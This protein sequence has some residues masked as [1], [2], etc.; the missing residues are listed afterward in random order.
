MKALYM[1]DSY[2]KEF[3]T[4]VKKADGKYIVLE[5][6]AFYPKS[7]GQPFDTGKIIDEE[8]NEYKVVFTGKFDGEISHEVDKEGLS[9]GKNVKGI[10]DWERRYKLMRAH[11]ASHILSAVFH[12]EAG[13]KITGNQL[14]LEKS[15]VD[16]SLEDFDRNRIDEYAEKANEIIN[17]NIDVKTYFLDREEAMKIPG[18]VKLAGALPPSVKELR[19]VEIGDI[20]KQADGGTHVKNTEEIGEIEIIKADN[21]GKNNRRVYFRLK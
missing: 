19:I 15:R 21:K 3:N 11:T 2:L 6:T 12:N 17:R 8:G 5:E 20:D 10:I 1:E 7:G 13:A 9:E 16:F 14:D 18:M 4:K